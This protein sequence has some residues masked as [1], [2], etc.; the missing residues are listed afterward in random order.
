LGR[1]RRTCLSVLMLFIMPCLSLFVPFSFLYDIIRGPALNVSSYSTWFNKCSV[2]PPAWAAAVVYQT[3][4]Q[5]PA[6]LWFAELT[7]ALLICCNLVCPSQCFLDL[8]NEL[9]CFL[10]FDKITVQ[11]LSR[12]M[13]YHKCINESSAENRQMVNWSVIA[14]CC[15]QLYSMCNP[16]M[17]TFI[18]TLKLN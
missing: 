5:P 16:P 3:H 18:F 9:I 13:N 4:P 10:S 7:S 8:W 11:R 15:S 6:S 17:L 1:S 14:A 12:K 2:T